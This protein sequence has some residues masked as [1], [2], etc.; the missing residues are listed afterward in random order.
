MKSID[1][2]LDALVDEGVMR[3]VVGP[4]R[5]LRLRGQFAV[6]NQVGRFEIGAFFS[7]LLDRI[8]AVAQDPFVAVNDK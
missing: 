4:I 7:Q 5:E 3:D 2:F 1:E 6:E 8:A